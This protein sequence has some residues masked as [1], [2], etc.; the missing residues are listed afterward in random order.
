[1]PICWR[2]TRHCRGVLNLADTADEVSLAV[3]RDLKYG[4]DW[5]MALAGA[6]G[7]ES[8]GALRRKI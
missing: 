7:F 8:T 2:R 6:G 3:R 4:A 1:M 5:I